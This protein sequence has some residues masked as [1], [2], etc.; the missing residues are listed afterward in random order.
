MSGA[1]LIATQVALGMT[2]TANTGFAAG[3]GPRKPKK[4]KEPIN[5]RLWLLVSVLTAILLTVL[6]IRS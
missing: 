4:D 2:G 1:G 3:G 5:W 6:L